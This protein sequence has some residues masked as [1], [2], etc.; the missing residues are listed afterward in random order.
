METKAAEHKNSSK[1]HNQF[2][3]YV[4]KDKATH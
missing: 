3:H 2:K 1:L 4:G